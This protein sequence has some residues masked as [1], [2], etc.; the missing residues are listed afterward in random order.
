MHIKFCESKHNIAE[1]CTTLA[2]G[3][4]Q[5]YAKDDPNFLRCDYD[6]GRLLIHNDSKELD[7][8]ASQFYKL[9]GCSVIARGVKIADGGQY[10]R[11]L[12]FP[13]CYLFCFGHNVAPLLV[14]AQAIDPSYNSWYGITNIQLF[15]EAIA[16][17][18]IGQLT[19]NDIALPENAR[20][21]FIG[22]LR[23]S[24]VHGPVEYECRENIVTSNNLNEISDLSV[25]PIRWLFRKDKR[26]ST[27]PEY[28]IAFIITDRHGAQVPVKHSEKIKIINLIG[29]IGVKKVVVSGVE[30]K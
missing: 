19:I 12:T 3:T 28:R 22:G 26:Y 29:D 8:T 20:V 5:S 7:I 9:S 11:L 23:V 10:K 17:R 6:E 24:F 18:L 15:A 16:S 1:G 27:L 13:N 25:Q 30:S 21:D 2:L 14:N 4:L